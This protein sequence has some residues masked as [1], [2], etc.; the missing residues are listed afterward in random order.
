MLA[1][2]TLAWRTADGAVV[3]KQ[4]RVFMRPSAPTRRPRENAV[5]EGGLEAVE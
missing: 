3:V 4:A 5:Y 1:L 2:A